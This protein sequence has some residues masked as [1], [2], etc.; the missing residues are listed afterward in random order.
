MTREE[1]RKAARERAVITSPDYP[2][3]RRLLVP[4]LAPLVNMDSLCGFA[5]PVGEPDHRGCL[6]EVKGARLA[7]ANE[8]LTGKVEA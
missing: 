7:T 6:I 1:W 3:Y 2:C 4:S 5:M 8:L